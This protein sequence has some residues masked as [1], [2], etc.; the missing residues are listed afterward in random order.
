MTTIM[1]LLADSLPANRGEFIHQLATRLYPICRSLAGDGVRQSLAVISDH[2]PLNIHAVPTGTKLYDWQAPQEWQVRE[3]YIITPSGERIADFAR[4]NLHLVNFSLPI[5]AT[6]PLA[7]LRKH[8]HTLPEQPDLIPYRTCYH[9][10]DWGFCMRHRDFEV[11][12]EG[13]YQVVIDCE[14]RDGVMNYGEFIHRGDSDRTF[15]ITAHICHP[16]LANDNC[17]GLAVLTLLAA[18]L[19]SLNTRY[20]YRLLFAPANLG[21]LAW[22][23]H[24]EDQ[25]HNIEFGLVL[26]CLGDGGG[27]HYKRSRQGDADIDRV[28]A[29]VLRHCGL[30]E[31]KSLDFWPYG[32]DERQYCSPGFNLPVGMFQRSIY[33]TFP[34][35]HT[36]AD[37]LDFIRPEHLARSFELILQAIEIAENNWLPVSLSPYGEPQLGRR[38]LYHSV[39][40][41]PNAYQKNMATLW[42]LNLADGRHTL[43]DMA[44]RADLPFSLIAETADLLYEAGLLAPASL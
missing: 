18:T 1:S 38:G 39:G 13:D 2:I 35:Y 19:Q 29:Q 8:I 9:A 3:A 4:H 28:M 32:Y 7:E 27:P 44:E 10:D 14:R 16:A 37:D 5:R 40:G 15:L 21:A 24:N 23:A 6:M 20:T 33:G 17:S 22:L 34:Q 31:A 30:T 43:L 42:V 41:D 11:L 12:R 26:S 25:L 36:S